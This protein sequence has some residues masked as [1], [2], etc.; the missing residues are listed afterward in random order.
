MK[1][2]YITV[3]DLIKVLIDWPSDALVGAPR[4]NGYGE[5]YWSPIRK[6]AFFSGK[7]YWTDGKGKSHEMVDLIY[8][9]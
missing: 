1:N 3:K 2:E 5:V 6:D 8:K 7:E 9:C 4:R